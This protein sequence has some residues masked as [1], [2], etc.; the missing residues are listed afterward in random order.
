MPEAM[1]ECCNCDKVIEEY[2]SKRWDGT[3]NGKCEWEVY[4]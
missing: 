4:E 2:F 1:E 3:D